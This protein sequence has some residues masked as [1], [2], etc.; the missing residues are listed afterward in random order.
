MMKEMLGSSYL[1]GANAPF[2]EALYEAYLADPGSVEPRWRSYFD[3]L[4]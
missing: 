1:S 2:I 3:E 4:Q